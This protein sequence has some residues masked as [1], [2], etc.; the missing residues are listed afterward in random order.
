MT[1][2]PQATTDLALKI[3]T[4]SAALVVTAAVTWLILIAILTT[5]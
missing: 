5:V 2:A 3:S 4:K 1:T